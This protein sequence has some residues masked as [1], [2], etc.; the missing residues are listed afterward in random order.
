MNLLD[1]AVKNLFE[2]TKT[3]S[4]EQVGKEFV[5][6]VLESA[7]NNWEGHNHRDKA[8]YARL[9]MDFAVALEGSYDHEDKK[10]HGLGSYVYTGSEYL[11]TDR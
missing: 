6:Y 4:C 10:K 5:T 7:H 2:V 9:I 1:Q 8:A 11:T 3:K